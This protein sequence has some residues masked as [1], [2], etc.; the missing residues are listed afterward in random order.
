MRTGYTTGTCAA[1][2]A[3]AAAWDAFGGQKR[4][5]GMAR[6][7]D[8]RKVRLPVG[9]EREGNRTW[10]WVR[11]DAGDDPDVTDGCFVYAAV[12]P[13]EALT[14]AGEAGIGEK[15]REYREK[16]WYGSDEYPFLFLTG[17]PGIGVVT[18]P[19]LSCPVG[20]YALNP[21][22]RAMIFR[23]AGE[24]YE[25]LGMKGNYVIRIKIPAGRELAGK[26]F[27]PRLGIKGGISVLGTSGIV[28][29]MSEEALK[30]TI[31]LEIHMRRTGGEDSLILVPGNYGEEFLRKNL[32][33]S[34]D[35]AVRCSNFAAD[36]VRMAAREGIRKIL[37]VGHLG[38]LVKVAGGAENTHSRYGDRR[39]EILAECAEHAGACL[40]LPRTEEIKRRILG[41]NT[42]EEAIE[43][44]E[45]EGL[46]QQVM[47]DVTER[48]QRQM[49][50]WGEKKVQIEVLT[51]S[52]VYG[53]LGMSSF[54]EQM[55]Q[56]WRERQI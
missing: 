47:A 2:A 41:C 1:A 49:K 7:P 20:Y 43:C 31:G 10:F 27:N 23:A 42:T 44:L 48:I 8:G 50:E 56:E 34:I 36:A 29:P 22:P 17:G 35:R 45:R 26:T 46:R 28:N 5:W 6:L 4:A 12:E 15:V 14:D 54:C 13:A 30:D 24:V 51:F 33:I 3:C 39:M 11:K 55:I 18:K 40:H 21:V 32:G 25:E 53:I 19:G 16:A 38:K 52:S 37:F 9:T